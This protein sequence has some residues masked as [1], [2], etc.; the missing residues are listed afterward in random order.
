MKRIY[1]LEHADPLLDEIAEQ[2]KV[3]KSTAATLCI[4]DFHER[5]IKKEAI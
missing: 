5:K 2:L 1:I 4:L 3:D